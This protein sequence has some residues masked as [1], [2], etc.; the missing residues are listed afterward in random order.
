M[1]SKSLNEKLNFFEHIRLWWKFEARYYHRD[2]IQGVK[3]LIRW[4]PTIWKDR[5]WDDYF[6]FELLQRKLKHQAKHIRE[7][8]FHREAKRDA[9]IIETCIR[10]IT[11]VQSEEYNMEYMDYYKDDFDFVDSDTPSYKELKITEVSENLDEYFAKRKSAYRYVLK[12]GGIVGN[13]TKKH[14]AISMSHYTHNRARKI[15]FRLL[16]RN[17]ERWWV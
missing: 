4:F 12:H 3:N 13:D 10:L 14:I 9:E 1:K 6:L 16:E 15:L 5:D 2:L 11:L 8:D 17:V 7:S